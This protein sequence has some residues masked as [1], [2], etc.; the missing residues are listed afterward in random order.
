[1][2]GLRP[3]FPY[4]GSKWLAARGYP[5]PVYGQIVEPFAGSA[6][7]AL[8]YPDRDVLLVEKRPSVAELWKWL[9]G[10]DP[11]EIRALPLVPEGTTTDDFYLS[12]PQ[13]SLVGFHLN[14]G[15]C[16][17]AR[18]RSQFRSGKWNNKG[19]HEGIRERIARQVPRIRHWQVVEGDYK[20]SAELVEGLATW[21]IDPP[22]QGQVGKVYRMTPIDYPRL[23]DWC[24]AHKGQVIVCESARA[25][26]LPFQEI[27]R[28]TGVSGWSREACFVR[29]SEATR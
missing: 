28:T 18:R 2:S 11:D 10:A 13:R 17:P 26:W 7:Y 25:E 23:A 21:F 1:M 19:W 29:Y 27:W 9:I 6:G 20:L 5:P 8:R 4:Y 14:P 22:Y 24:R 16:T 3:F 15:N 12:G